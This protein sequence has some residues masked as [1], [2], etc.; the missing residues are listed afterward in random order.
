MYCTAEVSC[1]SSR[2]VSC[3][4]AYHV[5]LSMRC[6]R[7]KWNGVIRCSLQELRDKRT[8]LV[9][10]GFRQLI[11]SKEYLSSMIRDSQAVCCQYFP[12]TWRLHIYGF[13]RKHDLL[14]NILVC[15]AIYIQLLDYGLTVVE[16]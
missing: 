1:Y 9:S 6:I 15:S 14:F 8:L 16:D 12:L 10:E 5:F 2:F 13:T 4:R 7:H 11:K 3:S